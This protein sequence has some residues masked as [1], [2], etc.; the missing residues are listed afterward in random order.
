V[1]SDDLLNNV[2]F[3]F[4]KNNESLPVST[5]NMLNHNV[6][7]STL[8]LRNVTSSD[9]GE[10]V[11]QITT[12]FITIPSVQRTGSLLVYRGT[13]IDAVA[14]I[15][16]CVC[17]TD[18]LHI[19]SFTFSKVTN[20]N[21]SLTC[22]IRVHKDFIHRVEEITVVFKRQSFHDHTIVPKQTFTANEISASAVV[23]DIGLYKCIVTID[24]VSKSQS[25]D[26]KPSQTGEHTHASDQ[27]K[28]I[29][30]G[31]L[32]VIVFLCLVTC[33]L[34]FIICCR[35]PQKSGNGSYF[36]VFTKIKIGARYSTNSCASA[37]FVFNK[38]SVSDTS[39]FNCYHLN[40]YTV[41]EQLVVTIRVEHTL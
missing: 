26:I 16:D 13:N 25:V 29:L 32:G 9:N 27:L 24:S 31:G 17:I 3:I 28:S 5:P 35:C 36:N 21:I 20:G 40:H 37:D 1:H 2:K 6:I 38:T 22:D 4:K 41:K 14:I 11:C 33:L 19:I 12:I 7:T 15:H 30:L 8:S 39:L 10:C 23:K 34:L 18:A